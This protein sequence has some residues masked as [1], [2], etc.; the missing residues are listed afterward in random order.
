MRKFQIVMLA[1][2][3]VSAL[4]AVF[5]MSASAEVTLLAEWLV[6]GAAITAGE[7]ATTQEGELL[8]EDGAAAS[9]VLCTAIFDGF[10]LANG[11]D[12]VT[13]V[14]HLDGT[15]VTELGGVL[16]L[17][18]TTATGPDCVHVTGCAEG[19]EASPIKVWP[20]GLPWHT[21]LFLMANGTFLDDV[22]KENGTTFGYELECLVSG[23]LVT[24][25]CESGLTEFEVVNDADTGNAAIPAGAIG[26]PLAKC[27]IFGGELGKNQADALTEILLTSGL[28]LTVSSE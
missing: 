24:D 3:V 10:V 15:E 28:L 8:L 18:G 2:L 11:L 1:L 5:A 4:S 19:T 14:L 17:T 23:I 20:L 26:E 27:S 7:E 9:S 21:L 22:S 16:P 13:K 25:T 12:S 6:S